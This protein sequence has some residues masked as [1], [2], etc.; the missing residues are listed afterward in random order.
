MYD[1]RGVDQ[2]N[3]GKCYV[4]ELLMLHAQHNVCQTTT[5]RVHEGELRPILW[6]HG[7]AVRAERYMPHVVAARCSTFSLDNKGVL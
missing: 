5:K 7:M 4:Y 6:L 2:R 1:L 3:I